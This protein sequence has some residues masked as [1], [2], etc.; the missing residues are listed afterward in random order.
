MSLLIKN[1]KLI[2]DG[3]EVV[4]NILISDGKIAKISDE[5]VFADRMIDVN[6]KFVIPGVIDPHVHF[7][8]PGLTHKE[9]FFTGGCAAAAGGITTIIDM[10]N[11]KPPTVSAFDLEVKRK[12]ASKSIVNYGFH[13]GG[14]VDD[15][16]SEI[17]KVK[18]AASIKVFM[19]VSTGKML[20][21]DDELLERVFS[22]SSIVAVHAER[23]MVEKAIKISKRCGNRLYLCHISLGSEVDVLR[24]YKDSNIFAEVTPHHLFMTNKD[25]KRLKGFAEMKPELKSQEDQDEL[26]KAIK[27]GLIDTIGTDHAPHTIEEKKAKQY[28]AGVP[29]CETSLAL[30]LNAVNEG[31]TDL[32]T[33][34]RLMCSNPAKIFGIA[35][36]GK[37]AV[38]Y[39]ADLT[40]IDMELEKRVENG[41]L[42][43]KCGWNPFN[44]KILK[45]WP[46]TTIVGGNIVFHNN[47]LN[48]IPA[49]EIKVVE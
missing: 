14:S 34:V 22:A 29:G 39:D 41:R 40:V 24:R 5:I 28:P 10:P 35:G 30:M 3:E 33:V 19:N 13:F 9:D 6:K 18:N 8:E 11:T 4:K 7:R 25:V 48:N 37:I 36:K 21:E 49:K 44:G 15:N 26:W 16:V 38:G 17:K 43:T 42:Y 45:G 47:K 32:T 12:L 2:S 31:R 20:I 27:E 1:C 46:V 23:G